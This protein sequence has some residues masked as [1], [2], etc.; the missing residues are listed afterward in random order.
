LIR[1]TVKRAI[2]LIP[3][4]LGMTFTVFF[5]MRL[6]PGDVV[7]VMLAE[8]EAYAD[9]EV[10]EA[11]RRSFGLDQPLLVQFWDWFTAL[12]HGDL[13]TSFRTGQPVVTEIAQRMPATLQLAAAALFVSLL[14]SIPAGIITAVRRNGPVDSLARLISL[15]GLSMPNF[16]IGILLISVFSVT[17]GVLPAGGYVAPSED[18]VAH[19]RYLVMPAIT[20]GTA[21]AAVTMRMTR[22]SLIE[23]LG[24]DYVRTARAKGLRERKV[25][26]GHALRNALIPVVTI[27]G[28]QIANLLGGS[29]VVETVFSWPGIGSSIVRAIFQRDY[30]LVQGATLFLSLFFVL[31]N[32]LV[33]LAYVY[34]DPRLRHAVR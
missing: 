29:V 26:G 22:S 2:S 28:I 33:D 21:L 27:V 10:V 18:L 4:L 24:E 32:F 25:I 14:I 16:W 20:L 3:V 11:L 19:L 34:L 7:Q 23:T 12:L 1:E 5:V 15:I 6:I 13:G 9:P 8:A 17:L 31:C 30:P